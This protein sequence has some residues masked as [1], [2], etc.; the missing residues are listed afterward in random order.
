MRAISPYI[1]KKDL[2]SA[3]YCRYLYPGPE[4]TMPKL[5]LPGLNRMKGSPEDLN[6]QCMDDGSVM[7]EDAHGLGELLEKQKESEKKNSSSTVSVFQRLKTLGG[8]G[9]KKSDETVMTS[10]GNHGALDEDEDEEESSSSSSSDE[11]Y[12]YGKTKLPTTLL[13]LGNDSS[14]EEEDEGDAPL[15]YMP[16]DNKKVVDSALANAPF[17]KLKRPSLLAAPSGMNLTEGVHTF[18]ADKECPLRFMDS[19]PSKSASGAAS[20]MPSSSGQK[21]SR[22]TIL[23]APSGR[24]FDEEARTRPSTLVTPSR[25]YLETER[26][27]RPSMLAA[28]SGRNLAIGDHPGDRNVAADSPPKK[29]EK[30]TRQSISTPLGGE[31]VHSHDPAVSCDNDEQF[32]RPR[33]LPAPSGRDML[34]HVSPDRKPRPKVEKPFF[35][36]DDLTQKAPVPRARPRR[37]ADGSLRNGNSGGSVSIPTQAEKPH[38]RRLPSR[39]GGLKSPHK[40]NARTTTAKLRPRNCSRPVETGGHALEEA[41]QDGNDMLEIIEDDEVATGETHDRHSSSVVEEL[42][43]SASD[44]PDNTLTEELL[45]ER[46]NQ[47]GPSVVPPSPQLRVR[48]KISNSKEVK[49]PATPKSPKKDNLCR[50]QNPTQ[51]SGAPEM[52]RICPPV[53]PN[54]K[55]R[56]RGVSTQTNEVNPKTVPQSPKILKTPTRT[57]LGEDDEVPR[58]RLHSPNKHPKTPSS[59]KSNSP[60]KGAEKSKILADSRL[61]DALQSVAHTDNKKKPKES[62]SILS[63]G[64][65]M[66]APPSKSSQRQQILRAPSCSNF[67]MN[68]MVTKGICQGNSQR[69]SALRGHLGVESTC[70]NKRSSATVSGAVHDTNNHAKKGDR[71]SKLGDNRRSGAVSVAP[72]PCHLLGETEADTEEDVQEKEDENVV[73]RDIQFSNNIEHLLEKED[74]TEEMKELLDFLTASQHSKRRA[75]MSDIPK[76]MFNDGKIPQSGVLITKGLGS[77]RKSRCES[78]RRHSLSSVDQEEK[79]SYIDAPTSDK[80]VKN[81]E[82]GGLLSSNK[83]P[84][85]PV[86]KRRDAQS[87]IVGKTYEAHSRK[88]RPRSKASEDHDVRNRNKNAVARSNAGQKQNIA[89]DEHAGETSTNSDSRGA[90]SPKKLGEAALQNNL[91]KKSPIG[92]SKPKTHTGHEHRNEG[93]R[94]PRTSQARKAQG[95]KSLIE[96]G[97]G[98]PRSANYSE[99]EAHLV[100]E[101]KNEAA[102]SHAARK[103]ISAKISKNRKNHSRKPTD[104]VPRHRE[105]PTSVIGSGNN[106][107][108]SSKENRGENEGLGDVLGIQNGESAVHT[109]GNDDNQSLQS[110]QNETGIGVAAQLSFAQG[111]DQGNIGVKYND[112]VSVLGESFRCP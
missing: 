93:A 40:E 19:V 44:V 71:R 13:D 53:S 109:S 101:K 77:G 48:K 17:T 80:L 63:G 1:G 26:T 28:P 92:S 15:Q 9:K 62:E 86:K 65:F 29:G 38:R 112:V 12:Q 69:S 43:A 23:A 84:G 7:S 45:E 41:N 21:A 36:S 102:A 39:P 105:S 14:S 73:R 103:S 3:E 90:E 106:G 58:V 68:A 52:S 100:E 87:V 76:P 51:L 22:P 25:R 31:G 59:E 79:R 60:R 46:G 18:N 4:A 11:V 2:Q 98:K 99:S 27:S 56:R 70:R 50:R 95:N 96:G 33:L 10:F 91:Q 89:S 75:S 85:I 111:V 35:P 57:R 49:C 47:N 67:Q 30:A 6:F 108:P 8:R 64:G 97:Q 81:A 55:L 72:I 54:S 88:V 74:E 107:T 5:N 110:Y 82:I 16:K 34:E 24:N 37:R 20:V 66:I 32:P 42:N 83:I 94:R 104:R 61:L 78:G